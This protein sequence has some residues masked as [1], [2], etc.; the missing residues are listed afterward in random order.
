M[1]D[2]LVGLGARQQHEEVGAPGERGPR[3]HAIDPVAAVDG[4]RHRA[5]AGDVGAVV[6]FGDGDAHHQFS[7]RD[8]R[9]PPLLLLVGPAGDDGAG[10]DLGAGDERSADAER[11]PREFLGRD[12]HAEVV[13]LAAG[14]EPAVLLRDGEAEPAELGETGDEILGDVGIGAVDVLSDGTDLVRGEAVE[15]LGGE[16]EVVGEVA[17]S[18]PRTVEGGGDGLE[19]LGR[20]VLFDE[21]PRVGEYA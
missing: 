8:A 9:Q 7:R 6:R 4:R 21:R 20:A 14:R 1:G 13:G 3:L 5:H 10:E 18:G 17:R 19:E 2:A 11:T 16:L 15:C 12:D